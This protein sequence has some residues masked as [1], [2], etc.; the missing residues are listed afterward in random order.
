MV[1]PVMMKHLNFTSR[2]VRKNALKTLE[3]LLIAK[4]EPSNLE[5]FRKIY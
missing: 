2:M 1:L 4:G 5:L 3:Y